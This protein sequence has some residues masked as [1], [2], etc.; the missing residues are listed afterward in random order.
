MLTTAARGVRVGGSPPLQPRRGKP[1]EAGQRRG[2]RLYVNLFERASRGWKP[3]KVETCPV[4]ARC[5]IPMTQGGPKRRP[6]KMDAGPAPHLIRAPRLVV[7]RRLAGKPVLFVG[8]STSQHA[9]I[10]ARQN[11]PRSQHLASQCL[12]GWATL[13]TRRCVPSAAARDFGGSGSASDPTPT[14]D[15][16][17]GG[18][19]SHSRGP[20]C[21]CCVAC[22]HSQPGGTLVRQTL[23]RA[24][25]VAHFR[26]SPALRW[27]GAAGIRT[28]DLLIAKACPTPP[29]TGAYVA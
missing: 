27:G 12:P 24:S 25:P 26:W 3:M 14:A 17:N 28:P 9:G 19:P 4:C 15:G 13:H 6:R 23:V 11:E 22:T 18:R 29:V 5:R 10:D 16:S 21:M 7:R 8:S 2:G 1:K 20:P